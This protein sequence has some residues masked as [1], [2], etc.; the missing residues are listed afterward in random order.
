MKKEYRQK[1]SEFIRTESNL[2]SKSEDFPSDPKTSAALLKFRHA[3][4][5]WLTEVGG[6]KTI[7]KPEDILQRD[8]IVREQGGGEI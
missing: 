2:I 6:G 7:V 4:S 8:N 5:A 1:I 3:K